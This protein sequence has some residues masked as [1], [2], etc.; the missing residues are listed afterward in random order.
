VLVGIGSMDHGLLEILQGN[1]PTPGL[2]VNALG[3]GYRWTVWKEGGEGA[4]T[5]VPNFLVTGLLATLLGLLLILWSL[6][7]LHRKHG[8]MVFLLLGI[9]SF[10]AGGGIAQIVL[11]TLNWAAVTRIRASLGFWRRLIP[12]PACRFLGRWWRWTVAA[13]TTAFL[14]GLEIAVVGYVPGVSE[15]VRILHVCWTLVIGGIGL[16]LVSFLCGFAWDIAAGTPA[17]TD[18][19]TD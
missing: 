6:R 14:A 15:P 4:F 19:G 12:L 2:I 16:F 10:L 17:G 8:P 3:S 13:A 1:R 18:S 5:L 9:A 11:F 7:F